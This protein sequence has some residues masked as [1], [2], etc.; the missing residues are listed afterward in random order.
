MWK[1]V[2]DSPAGGSSVVR[3]RC[4]LLCGSANYAPLL[5]AGLTFNAAALTR[6]QMQLS[7]AAALPLGLRSCLSV[8]FNSK[9]QLQRRS[10]SPHLL[11]ENKRHCSH[12][13]LDDWSG[14]WALP[15]V[16]GMSGYE[17]FKY[18]F[19]FSQPPAALSMQKLDSTES[20]YTELNLKIHRLRIYASVN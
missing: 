3:H 7:N 6:R 18:I 16:L 10:R 4:W 15:A 14:N 20:N 1:C 5:D 12:S 8:A 13:Y 9:K 11:Q 19:T 17:L 2:S